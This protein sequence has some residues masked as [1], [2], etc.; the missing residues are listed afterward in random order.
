[1]ADQVLA[2]AIAAVAAVTA[3]ASAPTSAW[4]LA[5]DI[6]AAAT[7]TAAATANTN[8]VL[9]GTVAASASVTASA[10]RLC[11][12][13]GQ[14]IT[15]VA[16]VTAAAVTINPL[17]GAIAAVASA[18]FTVDVV[19]QGLLVRDCADAALRLLQAGCCKAR[20]EELCL[21]DAIMLQ[22]NAALQTIYARASE[23]AYFNRSTATVTVLAN[24][25]SVVLDSSIQG[26]H[27]PVR[28]S[29]SKI[30]LRQVTDAAQFEQ[31]SNTFYGSS[32][33]TG[34]RAYNLTTSTT[35][36]GDNVILTL[37]VAPTPTT[38]TP[39]LVDTIDEAPRYTWSDVTRGTAL[40]LPHKYAE[41]ILVPLVREWATGHEF[42]AYPNLMASI[43]QQA[44]QARAVLGL[45]DPDKPSGP[46]EKGT[47]TP[48]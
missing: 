22:I 44:Q 5:G 14:P 41:S 20:T 33:P 36:T 11:N 47:D 4:T 17:A 37:Q 2:G 9:A 10:V 38:N 13:E 43:T 16:T 23:L 45:I 18:N 8:Q 28:I 39:L 12:L 26:I 40:K 24:E 21:Q 48:A 7:V 31:F 27:G 1:M 25:S 3:S 34:P 19:G 29:A 6:A 15:A 30:Q 42:F 46:R 32:V 35:T